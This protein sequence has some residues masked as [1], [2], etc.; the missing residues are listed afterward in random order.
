[1]LQKDAIN[2]I[3]CFNSNK[4]LIQFTGIIFRRFFSEVLL[5]ISE[6][7]AQFGQMEVKAIEEIEEREKEIERGTF[8]FRMHNRSSIEA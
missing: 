5:S 1:M 7:C 8:F 6:W 3:A 2:E 4:K